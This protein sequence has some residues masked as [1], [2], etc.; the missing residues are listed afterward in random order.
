MSEL[1]REPQILDLERSQPTDP[2]ARLCPETWCAAT[3]DE[4]GLPPIQC[5]L[6]NISCANP[7]VVTTVSEGVDPKTG[8]LIVHR[9][10]L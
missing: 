1:E 3:S 7:C 5:M 9:W 10:Q 8:K 6:S 4:N 2:L